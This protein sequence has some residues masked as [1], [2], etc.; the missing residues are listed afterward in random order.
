MNNK[1]I[2]QFFLVLIFTFISPLIILANN[3]DNIEA[4]KFREICKKDL[5]FVQTQ[6]QKNSSPYA[7]KNDNHFK[8]WYK[9]GY[10]DTVK[11][12]DDILDQDDCY[13]VMKYYLN[14]FDLSHITLKGFYPLPLE[15]YPGIL[16]AK[17]NDKH[18]IIYKQNFINYLGEVNVGDII[19]HI[20]DIAIEDYHTNYLL[21]FYAND[22]SEATSIAASIYALILDGNGF[23]PV[24]QTITILHNN[25]SKIIQLKYT[26][27]EKDAAEIAKNIRQPSP[28]EKFKIELISNG[29]WI[30]IPSFLPQDDEIIYYSSMIS[31]LKND[32]SKEKYIV[33]DMRG[34]RGGGSK[35]SVPIIRNLWG[36]DYLKSMGR[37]HDFNEQ[38]IQKIR[39]S[40]ENFE[41]FKKYNDDESSKAYLLALKKNESFFLKKWSIYDSTDNLYTHKDNSAFKAKIYV[42]TDNFC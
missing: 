9:D 24:P 20:N 19:T 23:K 40:K 18:Y 12:I 3:N 25:K 15:Q 42:L 17:K 1:L 26:N 28:N 22:S 35:W 10:K 32:F 8:D 30:S 39:I 38:W 6:L 41:D 34:N 4:I 27:L 36:D 29:I 21:P 13:Y 2:S 37:E 33:F 31:R 7:N 16:S 14:G 11:L 5:D